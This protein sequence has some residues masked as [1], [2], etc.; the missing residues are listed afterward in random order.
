[1]LYGQPILLHPV[2]SITIV[3]KK[4]ALNGHNPPQS[5]LCLYNIL[6]VAEA[7]WNSDHHDFFTVVYPVTVIDITAQKCVPD[8]GACRFIIEV[9]KMH[10]GG[11]L[12][13]E[14]VQKFLVIRKS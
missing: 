9:G 6:D 3:G 14:V 1:M 10:H 4:Y 7:T 2:P 5:T 8:R 11:H 13:L 12:R